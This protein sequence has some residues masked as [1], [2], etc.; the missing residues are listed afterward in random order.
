MLMLLLRNHHTSDSDTTELLQEPESCQRNVVPRSSGFNSIDCTEKWNQSGWAASREETQEEQQSASHRRNPEERTL[1]PQAPPQPCDLRAP[2]WIQPSPGAISRAA[3]EIIWQE[4]VSSN[5]QV[6]LSS[7]DE[8]Q[9]SK[10]IR[11]AKE[12]PFVPVGMAGF[13]V[14]VAYGLYKLKN[15]GNT[16]MSIHLIHMQVAAQGFVVG[17]M[18][19][20][21]MYS[22]YRESWSNLISLR[23]RHAASVL[24]VLLD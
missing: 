21:M 17:A 11:K 6:S 13:A 15:R 7:Y 18:T 8:D 20:G 3:V 24:L 10:L 16:K 22:M 23:R 9:G 14:I 19:A 4:K 5:T 1:S 2:P 12:A